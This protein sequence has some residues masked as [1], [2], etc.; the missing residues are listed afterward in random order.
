MNKLF[1]TLLLILI[2]ACSTNNIDKQKTAL[3]KEL[4]PLLYLDEAANFL[5]LVT[6]DEQGLQDKC[7]LKAGEAM[8]LLQPLHAM[9]DEEIPKHVDSLDESTLLKCAENCHC[10]LYSDL[11]SN[12]SRK[13]KLLEDA[14]N[15]SK[16]KFVECANKSAKWLC[17][18]NLLKKLKSEVEPNP[19]GL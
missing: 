13:Q 2:T 3:K 9:I 10:G 18:S 1:L 4:S 5:M 8:S 19:E 7:N 11:T 14:Q 15:T 17:D 16:K 6:D 12:G